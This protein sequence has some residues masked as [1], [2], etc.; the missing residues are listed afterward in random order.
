MNRTGSNLFHRWRRAFVAGSL[1]VVMTALGDHATVDFNKSIEPLLVENC[2]KCHGP[3]KQ[4]GGLRLDLRAAALKGGD[5]GDPAILPKDGRHGKL[6][7][8]I[9]ARPESDSRM[10]PKGEMLKPDQV[11]LLRRWIE[12]GAVWPERTLAPTN[13]R[14]REMVVSEDDRKHWAFQPLGQFQLPPPHKRTRGTNPIDR[15]VTAK[16]AE[17]RLKL[18]P[19]ASKGILLRRLYLDLVGLPPSPEEVRSFVEDTSPTAYE[20][21]VDRLL[22]SPA[23]GERWGRHWLDLARYAD[24]KGYER[25]GDRPTAWHYRDFVIQAFNDDLPFD[26][27]ITWQLAGDEL[28]PTNL[29]A[30]IATAFIGLGSVVETDTKLADELAR[31]RYADLDD[32]ISTVGQAMLGL[33]LG[34]AR[35]HDH[36]YD[37]IP[38]RDYY[39]MLSVFTPLER[40]ELPLATG[41][42]LEAYRS[43]SE[44]HQRRLKAAK[45][46]LEDWLRPAKEAVGPKLLTAK[47]AGLKPG[48][49]EPKLGDSDFREAFTGEQRQEWDRL[50]SAVKEAEAGAPTPPPTAFTMGVVD[51]PPQDFLMKRGEATQPGEEVTPGFLT[52]L[53]RGKSAEDYLGPV[54]AQRRQAALATWMTD[55]E[56]GAGALLARV[57]VNRLWQHH[58]GEGLVRT[59]SDFGTQGELPSHPELLDWLAGELVRGGW[60]LKPLHKLM[61]MSATYQ[62]GEASGGLA[63]RRPSA[64][65]TGTGGVEPDADNHLLSGRRPQRLEAEILRDSILVVSGCLN[66]NMF[67]PGVKAPV[68]A[69]LNSAYN[70]FDPYP[71]DA[72]DSPET[73]RRSVYLFTKRSLR[74]PLLEVFDGADPSAT[75]ARRLPTTVAPQALALLNDTWVRARAKDFAQRLVREAGEDRTA[76]VHRA[77]ALALGRPPRADEVKAGLRFLSAQA[78]SRTDRGE[79][80][81]GQL[82]LTDFCHALFGLNEFL[83]AD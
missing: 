34:C 21:R 57:I 72:K 27:F 16:L 53:L 8:L 18:S 5:S 51:T 59:P 81:G 20:K 39:R 47:S 1:G 48:E 61:V 54:G 68:P 58:F 14:P 24:S 43:A 9:S 32:M 2:L 82:A 69:E 46:A 17:K 6:L 11:A 15:F 80:D 35:C 79:P 37:P 42:E 25:D 71:K 26:R 12:E 76:Q 44:A 7:Q 3:E 52:V 30:R 36:K 64:A 41:P 4:K 78:A 62:Q 77:Y 55:T 31:Y 73:W 50:K 56:H 83:Y 63:H 60:K 23:F 22:A 45:Q 29:T 70:T 28:A 75:C 40:R 10:P 33:T 65:A 66:T 74:Q 67:G 19:E 13:G 49:K 38:T